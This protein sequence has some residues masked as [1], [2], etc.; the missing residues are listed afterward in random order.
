MQRVECHPHPGQDEQLLM[1]LEENGQLG[2]GLLLLL[3]QGDPK[4]L[5]EELGG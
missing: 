4:K 5:E 1:R 3:L 2:E